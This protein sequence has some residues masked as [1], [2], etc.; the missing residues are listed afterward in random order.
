MLKIPK[1]IGFL[2]VSKKETKKGKKPCIITALGKLFEIV[3]SLS[4]TE[5]S[6]V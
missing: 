4:H 5:I 1:I 3:L 2:K 6:M